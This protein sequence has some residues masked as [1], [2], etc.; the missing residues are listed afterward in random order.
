MND[1]VWGVECEES[2]RSNCQALSYGQ[3]PE[4]IPL[5]LLEEQFRLSGIIL[6]EVGKLIAENF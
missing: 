6:N 1:P 5:K 3:M 4:W 2:G